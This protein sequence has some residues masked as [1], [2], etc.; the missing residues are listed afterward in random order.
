MPAIGSVAAL[1][2]YPVKSMLGEDLD[3]VAVTASGLDGDRAAALIDQQTG[4]VATA[5]HPRLWRGL[6]AFGAQWNGGSPRITM[7]DGTRIA[8]DD[9]AAGPLLSG[10]LDRD[11]RLSTVR[12][13]RATIARPDPEDVIEHGDDADV[14]YEILEIG[15]GTPG[16]TFV[17]F[18]PVHVITT[19][20]LARVG[21]EMARYRP[22]VVLD[23]PDGAAFAENDWIGRDLVIGPVRLRVITPTPRCAVPTLAHGDLPR[24]TDAVRTLLSENRIPVFDLG[25]QPCLGVYAEVLV[26]GTV[27]L[28]N[29]ATLS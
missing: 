18:A 25:A 8:V 10:L 5:K 24:R 2:R 26:G 22:N 11:V 4:A 14:P 12:P 7:P 17:D 1:R 3:Q 27:A 21:A 23:T 20:S 9:H 16:R 28:G 15:R 19:A 29:R 13:D 6:L